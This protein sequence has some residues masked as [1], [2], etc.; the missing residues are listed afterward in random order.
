MEFNEIEYKYAADN[1]SLNYF[2]YKCES[3]YKNDNISYYNI[4]NNLK[5]IVSNDYFYNAKDSNINILRYRVDNKSTYQEVTIKKN[6]GESISNRI[7]VNIKVDS[8]KETI[9]NFFEL[10]GYRYE[11]SIKKE[12]YIYDFKNCECVYYTVYKN[13]V[14]VGNFIEIE[15]KC[16]N[17]KDSYDI[18]NKFEHDLGLDGN[19]RLNDSLYELCR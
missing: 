8:D 6:T 10:L 2:K 7:E 5:Y 19:I 9:D 3:I 1:I 14:S 11:Y 18:I 15:A 13:G 16:D 4:Y 17:I 12:S